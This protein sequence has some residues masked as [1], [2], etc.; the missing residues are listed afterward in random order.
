M[1]LLADRCPTSG[2]AASGADPPAAAH[3]APPPGASVLELHALALQHTQFDAAALAVLAE[4]Q[5]RLGCERVSLG[6]CRRN[7]TVALDAL[8]SADAGERRHYSRLLQA[9]MEET[10]D[11]ASALRVPA[12][13][14]MAGAPLPAHETLAREAGATVA[15]VPVQSAGRMLGVMLFE[16]REPFDEAAWRAARDAALFVGPVL[17]MM[18]RLDAPVGGRWLPTRGLPRP[19]AGPPAQR[20]GRGAFWAAGALALAGFGAWPVPGEV[21]AP[22]RLEG[23]GQHIVAAPVDG[24]LARVAVRPGARV[25][26]GEVLLELDARDPE[27]A[28]QRWQA[29]AAQH[30]KQ[31]REA[32]TQDDPGAIAMARARL[33]QAQVQLAQ[34]EADLERTR[35]RA[36]IAGLV[37][38]G[39]LSQSQG[40]PVQRGQTLM[41][42]APAAQ[43]K[44]VAEVD[45]RDVAGLAPG[46]PARVLFATPGA[47]PRHLTLA[48]VSPV[49]LPLDG[50]NVFEVE[51]ALTPAAHPRETTPAGLP[52]GGLTGA[53]T[54]AR[55]DA[56]T[57]AATD[58]ATDTAA[59]R[60][61]QRGVI[62]IAL[63][64]RPRAAGW[65]Q[66]AR[67]V[68]RRFW[69]RWVG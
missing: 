31:Y 46:Q 50:R 23:G 33:L 38:G 43:L 66:A 19:A 28:R 63:D 53:G 60:P 56:A 35:V 54:N 20:L 41:T 36:P 16:R 5:R 13:P 10:V 24:Y 57:D 30:D 12:A 37:L 39:D 1:D 65:W 69:W 48:R 14:G 15:S 40:M 11:E 29:E 3:P 8:S 58:T 64:D 6:L 67:D 45:E 21:V 26:A 42:V 44:V 2:A 9:A 55:T 4:L 25:E 22:A 17:C 47:Q 62:R 61:G 7:G 34:A 51:G 59:L 18:W 32:L 68:W 52:A 27:L 49:A